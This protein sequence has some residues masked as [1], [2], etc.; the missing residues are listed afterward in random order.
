MITGDIGCYSLG[1]M[2]PLNAKDTC[3]CMG[4]SVSMGH[5]A[6]Q[7]LNR[8]GEET[9][10]VAVIGDSTFFHSGMTSLLHVA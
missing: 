9:K 1:A 4:A 2:K 10:V 5:G 8:T 3:I 7:I 6:Q